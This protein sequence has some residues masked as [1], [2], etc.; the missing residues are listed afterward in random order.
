MSR[1]AAADVGPGPLRHVPTT[2]ST[3]ADLADEARRGDA[4]GAVLVADHQTAGRGRLDRTWDDNAGDALLVSFRIPTGETEAGAVVRAVGAAA[5]A[6]SDA[7]CTASVLSK[8]PNDLVAVD[9]RSPGK[10]AG[11]LAEFIPGPEACV[12]VGVGVN[13]RPIAGQPGAT[14]VVEC[15]GPDD[16]DGLLAT[17]L[18][19]LAPRLVDPSGVAPEL[20]TRSSTIGSRVRV[21]FPGGNTLV[22]DAVALT[23]DGE[24]VVRSVDG[25]DHVVSSAD[26]VHLRPG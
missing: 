3:N 6:A 2:G 21:E 16:R 9:G 25:D 15:G 8:W 24:L 13:I 4:T 23:D 20:R 7:L 11:I 26:V 12:V 19:A 5:R 10:L 22:G 14:S 17:L 1:A 18:R